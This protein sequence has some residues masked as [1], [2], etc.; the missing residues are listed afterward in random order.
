M[1]RRSVP[2]TVDEYRSE[3]RNEVGWGGM[4]VSRCIGG[5]MAV[6]C[7]STSAVSVVTVWVAAVES[8][9]VMVTEGV[10]EK[11]S[12]PILNVTRTPIHRSTGQTD[13][14]V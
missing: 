3:A 14:G 7:P 12:G 1:V 8:V 4:W 5:A 9:A 13:V 11:E 10:A 6:L 2:P